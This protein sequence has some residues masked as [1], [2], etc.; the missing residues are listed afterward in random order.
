MEM[1]DSLNMRNP[2]ISIIIPTYNRAD[3][4]PQAIDS[5]LKQ[6]Y[7]NW[8]TMIVDDG[9]TDE[10][11]KVVKKYRDSRIHYIAHQSNLGSSSARN[12]GIK[13]TKGQF[14]AFL[15]S[16]DEWL[17][18]KLACQMQV[19]KNKSNHCGVVYTGGYMVKNNKE[20]LAKS[21]EI[22]LNNFYEKIL[23]KN[24]VGS[25]T[26]LIK[27]ECFDKVGLYDVSLINYQDWDMWIRISKYYQF[28]LVN[29]PLI[30]YHIHPD[31]LSENLAGIIEARKR[32]LFKH[33][34]ELKK[35][36]FVYSHHY[37]RIGNLSC[38]LGEIEEGR[39]F[40]S[41]GISIYP[42]H[43]KYYLSL[44]LSLFGSSFYKFSIQKAKALLK[45]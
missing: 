19:F 21:V 14:I 25:S 42:Y 34:N 38:L 28:I 32:I 26:V 27:R 5:V 1:K 29:L 39:K 13:K 11:E 20:I 8:E 2:K 45:L 22:N 17:S 16:D 40:I 7:R 41:Q 6:T 30:K 31:Q 12:T 10:T 43:L 23:F 24:I 44:F 18:E 15:D 37:Y 35:R 4:L 36:R 3:L 33:R 9:S